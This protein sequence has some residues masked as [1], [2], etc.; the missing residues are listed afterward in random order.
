MPPLLFA[1]EWP[2]VTRWPISAS[3]VERRC[4][5]GDR[6]AAAARLLSIATGSRGAR[7]GDLRHRLS[8]LPP[9][10]AGTFQ[11]TGRGRPGDRAG[12]GGGRGWPCQGL[13]KSSL[14]L[15]SSQ[16][17]VRSWAI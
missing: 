16:W 5:A 9:P 14:P 2:A 10:P 11:L 8:G 12:Q 1:G 15:V 13:V 3:P 6:A 4:S 7:A 17:L